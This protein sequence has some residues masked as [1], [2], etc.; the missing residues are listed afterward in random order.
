MKK[1]SIGWSYPSSTNA[2][3]FKFK[4]GCWTLEISDAGQPPTAIAA[5]ASRPDMMRLALTMPEPWCVYFLKYGR[6][7][8]ENHEPDL[9]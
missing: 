6:K 5:S 9:A 1:K 4:A 2:E 3:K 8:L 7:D